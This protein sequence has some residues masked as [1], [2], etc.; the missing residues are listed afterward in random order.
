MVRLHAGWD[1]EA[2]RVGLEERVPL[3]ERHPDH[4]RRRVDQPHDEA[5]CVTHDKRR[6]IKTY[7]WTDDPRWLL[8]LQDTDGNE[9]WHLYR[10]DLEHPDAAPVDLT[11][12]EIQHG[13]PGGGGG[14]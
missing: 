6:G 1:A 11:P 9:D 5:V 12:K 3:A 7:Y 13:A 4:G 14:Q 10:V 8:Y 2:V